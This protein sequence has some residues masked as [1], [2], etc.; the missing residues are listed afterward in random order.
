MVFMIL[1]FPLRVVAIPGVEAGY[2]K[3]GG[4]L[5]CYFVVSFFFIIWRSLLS[6]PS[7]VT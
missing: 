6:F 5:R 4:M 3:E 7:G 1:R 2:G